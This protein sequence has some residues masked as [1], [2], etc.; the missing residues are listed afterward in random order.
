[1][2]GRRPRQDGQT[3][4]AGGKLDGILWHA[5]FFTRE[6]L[7]GRVNHVRMAL[8]PHIALFLSSRELLYGQTWKRR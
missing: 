3:R 2:D 5:S 6:V 7:S 4:V 1:M 8:S